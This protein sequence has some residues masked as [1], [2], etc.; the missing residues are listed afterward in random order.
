MAILKLI[1]NETKLKYDV[2]KLSNKLFVI[3]RNN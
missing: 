1:N 2:D 3:D